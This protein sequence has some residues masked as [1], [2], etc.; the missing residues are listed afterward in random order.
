MMSK[1]ASEDC[2]A[3]W[4]KVFNNALFPTCSLFHM[5]IKF[6]VI[7]VKPLRYTIKV[8]SRVRKQCTFIDKWARL[9]TIVMHP[10]TGTW[11][12]IKVGV[13]LH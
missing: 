13:A 1:Q 12:S 3:H 9:M 5:S 4:N 8:L 10:Y 2:K 6:P 11:R 7:E